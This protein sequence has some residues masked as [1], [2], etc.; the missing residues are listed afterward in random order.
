MAG[1]GIPFLDLAANQVEFAKALDTAVAPSF[2]AMG[3]KIEGLTE[4]PAQV[5]AMDL[6]RLG[7]RHGGARQVLASA[8][9]PRRQT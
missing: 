1:S 5:Q 7:A 2:D 9:M 4:L 3:L 6:M 8:G